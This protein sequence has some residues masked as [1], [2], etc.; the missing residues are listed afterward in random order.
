MLN[1][2]LYSLAVIVTFWVTPFLIIEVIKT[3]D[4]TEG[5]LNDI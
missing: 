4:K 1:F 2:K 3:R 5:T